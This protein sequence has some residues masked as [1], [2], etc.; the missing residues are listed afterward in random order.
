MDS[1][2]SEAPEIQEGR[3]TGDNGRVKKIGQKFM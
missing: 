3:N 2:D 1:G